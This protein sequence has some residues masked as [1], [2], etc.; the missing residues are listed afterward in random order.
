MAASF[1]PAISHPG[2]HAIKIDDRTF[3]TRA[4]AVGHAPVVEIRTRIDAILQRRAFKVDEI[5]AEVLRLA[6]DVKERVGDFGRVGRWQVL[7]I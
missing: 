5:A 7:A 3:Y 1:Q 6:A 4:I 2:L